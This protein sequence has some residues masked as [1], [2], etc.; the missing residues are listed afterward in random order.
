MAAKVKIM[1]LDGCRTIALKTTQNS[2]SDLVHVCLLE[3]NFFFK[4]NFR[5]INYFLIFGNIMENKL[6]N[7]F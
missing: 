5:K 4:M 2:S 3:N 1:N 6:E 7:T